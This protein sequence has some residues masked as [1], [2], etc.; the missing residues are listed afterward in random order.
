MPKC[1]LYNNSTLP[2]F[3]SVAAR[4]SPLTPNTKTKQKPNAFFT[5]TFFRNCSVTKKKCV[6][7]SQQKA[8]EFLAFGV[9][10]LA[11]KS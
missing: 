10:S 11:A 8:M 5:T 4:A 1:V 9:H 7:K 6:S 3:V 2:F